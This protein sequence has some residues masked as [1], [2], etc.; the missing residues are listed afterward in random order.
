MPKLL[1]ESQFF[2]LEEPTGGII[3]D[4]AL[5]P[6]QIVAAIRSEMKT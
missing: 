3:V 2:D 1:I 6:E 4:A 5:P